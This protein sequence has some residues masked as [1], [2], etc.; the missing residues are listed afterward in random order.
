MARRRKISYKVPPVKML[1][2][3]SYLNNTNYQQ[4]A[5]PESFLSGNMDRT[6][7]S[8]QNP[9][10]FVPTYLPNNTHWNQGSNDTLNLSGLSMQGNKLLGNASKGVMQQNAIN[11]GKPLVENV[12]QAKESV[13]T[14]SSE[15]NPANK[16]E[17]KNE[18]I[19]EVMSSV[20][21]PQNKLEQLYKPV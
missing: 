6:S 8:A 5:T 7:Q 17:F 14:F 9:N 13:N 12:N 10:A 20:E 15:I 3:E 19:S 11:S 16:S 2:H 4:F 18:V 21:Q 1:P